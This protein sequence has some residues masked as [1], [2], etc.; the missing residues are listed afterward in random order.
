M[1]RKI[2]KNI[3]YQLIKLYKNIKMKLILFFLVVLFGMVISQRYNCPSD[4]YSCLIGQKCCPQSWPFTLYN[5]CENSTECCGSNCCSE[6]QNC[7]GNPLDQKGTSCCDK[8]TTICCGDLPGC[9]NKNDYHCCKDIACK[10]SESCCK[11]PKFSYETG[12][13]NTC[14]P[15][16]TNCCDSK[17]FNYCCPG[18]HPLYVISIISIIILLCFIIFIGFGKIPRFNLIKNQTFILNYGTTQMQNSN[19]SSDETFLDELVVCDNYDI[20]LKNITSI[21]NGKFKKQSTIYLFVKII[22]LTFSI[23]FRCQIA[24]FILVIILFSV[25][26][27]HFLICWMKLSI[28]S[29]YIHWLSM[30]LGCSLGLTSFVYAFYG[31]IYQMTANIIIFITSIL[32]YSTFS[33]IYIINKRGNILSISFGNILGMAGTTVTVSS[34]QIT[35]LEIKFEDFIKPTI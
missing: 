30:L 14:C 3:Y 5:C 22:F 20:L 8:K 7:C 6:N 9:Y 28:N 29:V 2:D 17:F 25:R 35:N 11:L 33:P 24:V 27:L 16:F 19:Y 18:F 15:Q 12:S 10:S 32:M 4:R 1:T 34:F 21:V 23:I 26:L 13:E 31:E